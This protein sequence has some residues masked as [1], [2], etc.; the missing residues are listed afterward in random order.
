M[1]DDNIVVVVVVVFYVLLPIL[2]QIQVY[3]NHS[4]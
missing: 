4:V 3:L 1:E 2:K